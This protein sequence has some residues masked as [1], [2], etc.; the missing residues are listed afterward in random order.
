MDNNGTP[1]WN[2]LWA[3]GHAVS[4]KAPQLV[5]N[6]SSGVGSSLEHF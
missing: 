3:D 6:L 4:I 1:M 2:G 5:T